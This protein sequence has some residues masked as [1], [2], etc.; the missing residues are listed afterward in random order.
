[1]VI[2]S[3]F[4]APRGVP[5]F[6]CGWDNTSGSVLWTHDINKAYLFEESDAH[7][8]A[9]LK[10]GTNYESRGFVAIESLDNMLISMVMDS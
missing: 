3:Y 9:S 10:W 4:V 2:V 8:W 6:A 5:R 1:M 7:E